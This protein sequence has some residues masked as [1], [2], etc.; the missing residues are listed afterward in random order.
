MD[1]VCQ[2][3][4]C[5]HLIEPYSI[6]LYDIIFIKKLVVWLLMDSSGDHILPPYLGFAVLFY[7]FFLT[8]ESSRSSYVLW[9]L[10]SILQNYLLCVITKVDRVWL[11]FWQ[12]FPWMEGDK[13]E[14][15]FKI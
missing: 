12:T 6:S 8:I 5:V 11:I 2:F 14:K 9:L 15:H 13:T 1:G 4:F 10:Q 7:N 3:F